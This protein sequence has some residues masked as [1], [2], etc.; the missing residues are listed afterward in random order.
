MPDNES[1]KPTDYSLGE[2]VVFE[3]VN[4]GEWIA[5]QAKPDRPLE[6]INKQ[7]NKINFWDW[8]PN[9]LVKNFLMTSED[10]NNGDYHRLV[11]RG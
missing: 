4:P 10:F 3:K 9:K 11:I 8:E 2:R 1:I 5:S 7:G 6:V